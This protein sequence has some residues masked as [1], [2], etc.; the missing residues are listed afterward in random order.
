MKKV[1]MIG[2]TGA[3]KTTLCQAL[4]ERE[5]SYKKTQAIQVLDHCLID[6]PGEYM[7]NRSLYRALNVTSAGAEFIFLLQDCVNLSNVFPPG[8][9]M[10]FQ[11]KPVYGIV[12]KTDLAQED[13]EILRAE[14]NLKA[15]GCRKVYRV[16]NTQKEGLT[17]LRELLEMESK[18][19][20]ISNT[21]KDPA[22]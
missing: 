21:D 8:F 4:F 1:I 12:T 18:D 17:A 15:A 22:G 14:K 13:K 3:G 19:E 20:T 5:L 9:A 10:M 7:E 16:S 2:R 11:G 6:T